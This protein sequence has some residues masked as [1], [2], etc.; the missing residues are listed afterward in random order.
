VDYGTVTLQHLPAH[1]V[2][3]ETSARLLVFARPGMTATTTGCGEEHARIRHGSQ[4]I[5]RGIATT[6]VPV[7]DADLGT[8]Q[9]TSTDPRAG[10][11]AASVNFKVMACSENTYCCSYAN[12][13][14]P[15]VGFTFDCCDD[16]ARAFTAGPA[17]HVAG[18]TVTTKMFVGF[19]TVSGYAKPESASSSSVSSA[20]KQSASS[21]PSSSTTPSTNSSV[22]SSIT[23]STSQTTESA[24]SPSVTTVTPTEAIDASLAT[25]SSLPASSTSSGDSG[26]STGASAGI[27]VGATVGALALIAIGVFAGLRIRKRGVAGRTSETESQAL[28]RSHEQWGLQPAY[29]QVSSREDKDAV[30]GINEGGWQLPSEADSMPRGELEGHPVDKS[31]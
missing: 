28:D 21:S 5:V 7:S 19:T 29:S 17:I 12:G 31:R 13:F 23:S 4:R 15:P 3:L 10:D 22:P 26:L 2:L 1:A 6:R 27:G 25:G 9:A 24:A 11:N 30:V 14:Y 8:L 20:Q 18:G 16:P